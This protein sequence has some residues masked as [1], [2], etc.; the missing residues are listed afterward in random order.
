M[1]ILSTFLIS[2]ELLFKSILIFAQNFIKKFLL[3]KKYHLNILIFFLLN[4]LP[5]SSIAE[6]S[7]VRNLDLEE[8]KTCLRKSNFKECKKLILIMERL[9]IEASNK[10]NFK[11]QTTLLGIQSELVKNFY[12]EKNDVSSEFINPDLIKNC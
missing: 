10:G 12:L 9:Q 4:V 2:N 8:L 1:L 3:K 11:C 7:I 5:Y 6:A